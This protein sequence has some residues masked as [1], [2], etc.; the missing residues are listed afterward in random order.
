MRSPVTDS[1]KQ[2][3]DS[4]YILT[5][6]TDHKFSWFADRR[7]MC[8]TCNQVFS[9]CTLLRSHQVALPSHRPF[10]CNLC[11][12]AS[13]RL[14]NLDNHKKRMHKGNIAQILLSDESIL[15]ECLS[16]EDPHSSEEDAEVPRGPLLRSSRSPFS[17]REDRKTE[18]VVEDESMRNNIKDEVMEECKY[19]F[20][21]CTD[22][23]ILNIF[24]V[25]PRF[26]FPAVI[27]FRGTN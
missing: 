22:G 15:P 24:L 2:I 23:R 8:T 10:K 20:H 4:V 17:G 19:E 11:D 16:I 13:L 9:N 18:P 27:V 6:F 14:W 7:F 12:Y 26:T 21:V 25:F 3:N 1:G 5:L